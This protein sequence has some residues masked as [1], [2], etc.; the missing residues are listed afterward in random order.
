MNGARGAPEHS[1]G[2]W[3]GKITL[4]KMKKM[5]IIKN[6]WCLTGPAG[7]ARPSEA[8]LPAF[9]WVMRWPRR[10]PASKIWLPGWAAAPRLGRAAKVAKC[11]NE[12][13][14]FGPVRKK[15]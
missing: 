1:P 10:P 4:A 14:F 12:S 11:K 5:K 9:S 15:H 8:G 13:V 3:S 2:G 6:E 7:V